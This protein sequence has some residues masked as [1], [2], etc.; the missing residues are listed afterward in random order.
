MS[1]HLLLGRLGL[2]SNG[3]HTPSLC[4]VS[5]SRYVGPILF[6]L[7][8]QSNQQSDR[9]QTF[10]TLQIT[11]YT[12]VVS[13]MVFVRILRGT[14]HLTENTVRHWVVWLGSVA[15]C[16]IAAF[17]IAESIPVFGDLVGLI[18]ALL[19]SMMCMQSMGVMWLF[20]NWARRHTDK[21]LL[22][23]ALVVFNIFLIL[24]GFF[25]QITG[26]WASV[27]AIRKS[28]AQGGA[29]RY[30]VDRSDIPFLQRAEVKFLWFLLI[31][32]LAICMVFARLQL[33]LR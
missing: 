12:H 19:G 9:S 20:D 33:Q 1:R 25:V 4:L 28:A 29:S 7:S 27:I 14:H 11:I 17:I 18:G 13:K 15:A 22:Y 23:R 21:T 16:V 10:L 26:T 8:N 5:L 24:S 3:S 2:S 30:V 32:L 31:A 6:W